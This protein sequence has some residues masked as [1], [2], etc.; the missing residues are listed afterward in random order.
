[1]ERYLETVALRNDLTLKE[2][3]LLFYLNQ[4]D[5]PRSKKDLA[6]FTG[7]S[8][9]GL[10]L[11]LQRL[12]SKDL[13]KVTSASET[14]QKSGEKLLQIELLP[15]GL[16]LLPELSTVR[17][18]FDAVRFDGFTEDELD[19]YNRLSNKIKENIQKVLMI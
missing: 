15:A 14:S 16:D 12:S 13:I 17:S 5:T 2:V 8:K 11:T 4:T 18:D 3:T 19:A 10:S 7:M 6:D 9:N 1:M